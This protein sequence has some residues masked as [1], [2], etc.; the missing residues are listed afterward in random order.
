MHVKRSFAQFIADTAIACHIEKSCESKMQ[1]LRE[2]SIRSR[3]V[4]MYVCRSIMK[5]TQVSIDPFNLD[6]NGVES[7]YKNTSL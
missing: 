6:A 4:H 2:K 7:R 1:P 5:F 3:P